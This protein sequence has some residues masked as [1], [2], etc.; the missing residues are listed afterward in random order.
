MKRVG[1]VEESRHNWRGSSS[2]A[3]PEEAENLPTDRAG[4][5]G[6][7][8]RQ[9]AGFVEGMFARQLNRNKLIRTFCLKTEL[10]FANSAVFA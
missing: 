8:P 2:S 7:Q 5:T 9:D 4:T 1:W 10:L 6:L 3:K